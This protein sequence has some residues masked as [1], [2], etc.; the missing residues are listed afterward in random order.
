[1]TAFFPGLKPLSLWERGW[2]EGLTAVN[3]IVFSPHPRPPLLLASCPPPLQAALCAFKSVPDGV[4]P[5]GG[6]N[7]FMRLP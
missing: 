5:V 6:E 1:M 4:V 2:G 7:W 3:A